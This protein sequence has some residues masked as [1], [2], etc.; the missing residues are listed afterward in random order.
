MLACAS[1]IFFG[2]LLVNFTPRQ[3]RHSQCLFFHQVKCQLRTMILTGA[4]LNNDSSYVSLLNFAK[5]GCR[6][7]MIH[8]S[9][10]KRRVTKRQGCRL[11]SAVKGSHDPSA[12]FWRPISPFSDDGFEYEGAR[13]KCYT[14][15][16]STSI[17][18]CVAYS[19]WGTSSAC[20]FYAQWRLHI[21]NNEGPA[22][23]GTNLIILA[24]LDSQARG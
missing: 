24:K 3:A 16:S 9:V 7:Q 18:D 23:V 15:L 5:P 13:L 8:T 6:L 21:T 10:S 1:L 11:G 12:T 20:L 19:S 14:I 4:S 22:C 17:V 2:A